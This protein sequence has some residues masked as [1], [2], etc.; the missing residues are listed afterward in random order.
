[1]FLDNK[2]TQW[3]YSIIENS[4]RRIL[5]GYSEKHH[6]LPKSMGG[7]DIRE[8]IAKLTAKEHFVCHLLLIRMTTGQDKK[9]M[10]HAVWSFVRKSKN[11]D[12]IKITGKRYERIRLEVSEMMSNSR[13]GIL[14]KGRILTPEMKKHLSDKLKGLPKSEE[15][16]N[17][18]KESWK[19]RPPRS[20]AHSMAIS[21][22]TK[23]KKLSAETKKKMSESHKGRTPIHTLISFHCEHCGKEGTG[24]GNYKR[25]HG[26]NCSRK[27]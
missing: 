3:Y 17:K 12:R 15:T 5:E 19:N 13:K 1:M 14:N 4:Q 21:A 27:G 8:N 22:A 20:K 7:S 10:L 24:I 6:I 9:K 18:M 25:W 16:K 11:Q 2:Y 23:G 26:D